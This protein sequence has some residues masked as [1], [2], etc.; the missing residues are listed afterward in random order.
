MITISWLN[1]INF[2]D[3]LIEIDIHNIA[4][5]LWYWILFS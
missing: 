3:Q 1:I 5:F 2:I 4:V